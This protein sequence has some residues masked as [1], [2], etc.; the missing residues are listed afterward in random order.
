VILTLGT[1]G[2]L[3]NAAKNVTQNNRWITDRLPAM[4]TAPKDTAGAGDALM[5]VTA[6]ALASGRSIWEAVYMGSLAA[7]CQVGRVGNIPL[8][9]AELSQELEF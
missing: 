6:L 3:I 2:I 7:A 4:S 1:E 8:T 9:I 5:V